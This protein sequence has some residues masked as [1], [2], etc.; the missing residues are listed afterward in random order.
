[1]KVILDRIIERKE[2]LLSLFDRLDEEIDKRDRARVRIGNLKIEMTLCRN[3]ID[4]LEWAV[5]QTQEKKQ[6]FSRTEDDQQT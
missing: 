5:K 4:T 6:H 3:D 2:R 1:M